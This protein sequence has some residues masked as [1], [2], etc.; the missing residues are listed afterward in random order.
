MQI[1]E[2]SY[3][4]GSLY[5]VHLEYC[6][7]YLSLGGKCLECASMPYACLG[8]DAGNLGREVHRSMTVL[9]YHKSKRSHAKT[10]SLLYKDRVHLVVGEKSLDRFVQIGVDF[11]L[12]VLNW[13]NNMT[14]RLQL[15]DIAGERLPTL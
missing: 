10:S 7:L 12:K 9:Y 14:I 1:S 3:K 2:R 4:H 6:T 13:D 15:W 8:K 11:A 5:A